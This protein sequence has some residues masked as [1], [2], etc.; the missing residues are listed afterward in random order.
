MNSRRTLVDR[1]TGRPDD[2]RYFMTWTIIVFISLLLLSRP[3]AADDYDDAL[4]VNA[5]TGL[6]AS[7]TG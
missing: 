6:P 2:W 4:V 3:V 5:V 7:V 1:V